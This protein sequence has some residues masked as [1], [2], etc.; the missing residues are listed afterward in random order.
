M[1]NCK[2]SLTWSVVNAPSD[3][4]FVF[5]LDS[6]LLPTQPV[7]AMLNGLVSKWSVMTCLVSSQHMQN[8]QPMNYV[9]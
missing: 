9:S 7:F 2:C 6:Y 8:F 1:V 3:C 5:P 4:L